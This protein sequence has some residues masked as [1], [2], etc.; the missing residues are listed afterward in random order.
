MYETL[1]R[2]FRQGGYGE[3]QSS[4][5]AVAIACKDGKLPANI[6]K[7]D[8]LFSLYELI[9]DKSEFAPLKEAVMQRLTAGRGE[10][11]LCEHA[12]KYANKELGVCMLKRLLELNGVKHC[13]D[14]ILASLYDGHAIYEKLEYSMGANSLNWRRAVCDWAKAEIYF[15]GGRS[16]EHASI[17][18]SATSC[19]AEG[20]DLK[21]TYDKAV[22]IM[23]ETASQFQQLANLYNQQLRETGSASSA[24]KETM[25]KMKQI[26]TFKDWAQWR[27]Q[28]N[29]GAL[30]RANMMGL[31]ARNLADYVEVLEATTLHPN[32]VAGSDFLKAMN[33][34]ADSAASKILQSEELDLGAWVRVLNLATK[35]GLNSLRTKAVQMLS[36][37]SKE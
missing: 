2:Q 34:L 22:E 31:L 28:H 10:S 25:R 19:H 35:F 26:G 9:D 3:E 29:D 8:F 30:D 18:A 14:W 24:R 20:G 16:F 36:R 5:W 12:C 1:E 15:S 11:W 6:D 21:D 7:P 32:S 27:M 13:N 17:L 33:K 4:L 23:I 37:G